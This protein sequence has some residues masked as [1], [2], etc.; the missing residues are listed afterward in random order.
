MDAV[1]RMRKQAHKYGYLRSNAYNTV[2]ESGGYIEVPRSIRHI[3]TFLL[4][5]RW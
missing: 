5:T 1:Q 4:T 2:T 3:Y